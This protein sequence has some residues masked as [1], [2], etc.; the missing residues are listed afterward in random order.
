MKSFTATGLGQVPQSIRHSFNKSLLGYLQVCKRAR[1]SCTWLL[2][3]GYLECS[4]HL[5]L[6]ELN[7]L[8]EFVHCCL[9]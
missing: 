9:L 3:D 4:S 1:L 2:Y 6:L 5:P 8:Q 7:L